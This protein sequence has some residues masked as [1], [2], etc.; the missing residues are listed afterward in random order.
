MTKGSVVCYLT[1]IEQVTETDCSNWNQFYIDKQNCIYKWNKLYKT[2]IRCC[3]VKFISRFYGARVA[4]CL[5]VYVAF[6]RSLLIFC[7]FSLGY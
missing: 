4:Q 6:Y 2:D 1:G 5:V 7:R 3:T